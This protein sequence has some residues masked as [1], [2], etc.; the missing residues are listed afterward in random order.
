MNLFAPR[1]VSLVAVASFLFG[2]CSAD[3]PVPFGGE[4]EGGAAGVEELSGAN[5]N[6]DQEVDA[7]AVDEVSSADTDQR[8]QAD[9]PTP[10][11]RIT[12]AA[13][14]GPVPAV[15]TGPLS[16]ELVESLDSLF[17]SLT[18]TPDLKA[19]DRIGDSEDAR[20]A[21]LLTDLLRFI[22][23]GEPFDVLVDAWSE[24]TGVDLPSGESAWG[25]TS[26]H[27]IAWNLPA[28]P[29]Y[30]N[31]KGQLFELVDQRWAP[32][33]ADPDATVDWRWVSWGGVLLDDRPIEATTTGCPRGC[34]PALNDPGLTDASGGSWFSD[35]S[36]VFG[37][38]V[39]DEAVAFP[40]NI[41]EIHEMVNITIGGRR[42]GIP[43]CTL[44]GSA[45]AYFTDEVASDIDLGQYQTYELRTSGLL[46]RSNKVMFEFH[47]RSVIDTFTGEAQSGPLREAGVVFP[48][49]TVRTSTW[50]DWKAAYPH[51]KIV[52]EDGGIGRS[53]PRDPLRGRDDRGP[54]FPIG[55]VD[56]R[57]EVQQPVIGVI[58]DSGTPVAFAVSSVEPLTASGNSV[59]FGGVTIA[60]DG[61]GFVAT[62][63]NTGETLAAHQAFWFAWSQFHTDTLLY[64]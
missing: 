51:T 23:R 35:D 21:W 44:C 20:V 41:M 10:Q 33:F 45:Q 18:T 30:V 63:T 25:F 64:S 27:L 55:D 60:S 6:I 52:A 57:L 42:L 37:V 13:S 29:G 16:E 14:F 58:S 56:G 39:G 43:Y 8:A 22:N 2:A 11:P 61:A 62:S 31:W 19:I 34:I 59:S 5:A 47:T 32:F 46:S 12:N 1:I 48:Q 28:P 15:A 26:N 36:I 3:D 24:L 53:Y 17:A 40:K 4:A 38:V 49:T 9:E 54:I 7:A 50:G